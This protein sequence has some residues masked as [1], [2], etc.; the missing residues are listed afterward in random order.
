[1]PTLNSALPLPLKKL[2]TARKEENELTDMKLSEELSK[3]SQV[4]GT[5]AHGL[6]LFRR[7]EDKEVGRK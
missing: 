3:Y 1:M 5:R 2:Q 6:H 7:T 4:K